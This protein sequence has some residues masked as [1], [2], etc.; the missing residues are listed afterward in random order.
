MTDIEPASQSRR[1][2]CFAF[3]CLIPLVLVVILVVGGFFAGRAYVR[4][5][6]D[7]WREDSPIFDLAVAIFGV[8]RDAASPPPPG[9]M[10]GDSD[11]AH[12]PT[13]V[14]TYRAVTPPVVHIS[15]TVTVFQETAEPH[16]TVAERLT[17]DLAKAGW[18]LLSDDDTPGGRALVWSSDARVCTY[19][20]V[21]GMKAVTEV[22]IRCRP[23]LE[24]SPR[25]GA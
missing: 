25:S 23:I 19:E 14:V 15:D 6:I 16:E 10:G 21:E 20:V 7:E 1:V 24:E 11:P 3:G 5:H 8:N 12:L 18:D 22:W 17:D 2:G 4:G 9:P 13:D